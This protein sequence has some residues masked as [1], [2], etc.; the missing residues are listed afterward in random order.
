MR[1]NRRIGLNPFI[2]INKN[3]SHPANHCES[4]NQ[5]SPLVR[6]LSQ[7]RA[8]FIHDRTRSLYLFDVRYGIGI[9]HQRFA[10]LFVRIQI[11][12][13]DQRDKVPFTLFNAKLRPEKNQELN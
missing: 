3:D 11:R 9:F 12:K 4:S 6:D 1:I 2:N 5:I 7:E 13:P 10:V 8:V